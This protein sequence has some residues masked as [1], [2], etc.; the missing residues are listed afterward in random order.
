MSHSLSRTRVYQST[1][2]VNE[3]K[4]RPLSTAQYSSNRAFGKDILNQVYNIRKKP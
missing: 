4:S 2:T 3:N 1:R